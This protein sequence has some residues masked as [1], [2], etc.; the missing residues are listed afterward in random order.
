MPLRESI[1]VNGGT[2]RNRKLFGG[3]GRRAGDHLDIAPALVAHLH[4]FT[5]P[6]AFRVKIAEPAGFLVPAINAPEPAMEPVRAS[7]AASQV[8]G[9]PVGP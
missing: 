1:Q 9:L 5:L 7:L 3:C 6:P 4:S 8:P 2:I